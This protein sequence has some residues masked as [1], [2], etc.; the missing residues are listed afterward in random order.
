MGNARFE[1]GDFDILTDGVITLA[2]DRKIPANPI[3]GH[4]PSYQFNVMLH[5]STGKIGSIRLRVGDDP[6]LRIAGHIGFE[7]DELHRGHRYATRACFLLREVIRAHHLDP[8]IITCDP[9]NL[10]SRRTCELIGAT[11]RGVELVPT[12]HEMYAKGARRVCRYEWRP[13]TGG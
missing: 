12:D 1:F 6:A 10:A 13:A 3:T 9:E 4:A 5:G 2:I 7:I 8:V 11:F